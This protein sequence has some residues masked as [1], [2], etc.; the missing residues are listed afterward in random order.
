M[1]SH[2]IGKIV[3]SSCGLLPFATISLDLP[4]GSEIIESRL[5]PD[6]ATLHAVAK[7]P[8]SIAAVTISTILLSY[9]K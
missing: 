2:D 4:G 7:T 5:S 9:R 3:L 8:D 6:F 1:V